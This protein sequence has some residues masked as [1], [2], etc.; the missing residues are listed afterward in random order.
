MTL[1]LLCCI[2]LLMCFAQTSCAQGSGQ[3]SV[4]SIKHLAKASGHAVVGS[5]KVATVIVA[6]PLAMIGG[7]GQVSQKS[8]D[9][10][11]QFARKPLLISDEVMIADQSPNL[12]MK[13]L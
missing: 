11:I 1:R 2:A 4:Q 3:H 7:V 12:A 8:S 5:I 9:Q 13:N 6:A 10:L